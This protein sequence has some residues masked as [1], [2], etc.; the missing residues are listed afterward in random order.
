MNFLNLS[1]FYDL[2]LLIIVGYFIFRGSRKGALNYF[3]SLLALVVAYPLACPL[4]TFLIS[5]FPREV[6]QRMQGDA[7]AFTTILILLYLLIQALFWLLLIIL[8]RFVEDFSDKLAGA[9][10]GLIKGLVIGSI[11]ILLSLSFNPAKLSLFKDSHLTRLASYILD[12]ISKPFPRYLKQKFIRKR[13][14]L[15]LYWKQIDQ[16]KP[17]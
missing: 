2:S 8:N 3:Y 6:V 12:Y 9:I 17:W 10:L 7:I 14:E 13:R 16:K 4:F 5:F 1:F 11:I 15:E